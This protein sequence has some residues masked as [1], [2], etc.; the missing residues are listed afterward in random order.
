MSDKEFILIEI[1]TTAFDIAL[2]I[3]NPKDEETWRKLR[4]NKQKLKKQGGTKTDL[5]AA[6][7][8]G[9]QDGQTYVKAFLEEKG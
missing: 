7:E 1:Q 6:I 9:I 4:K 2:G 3:I 8:A 5:N